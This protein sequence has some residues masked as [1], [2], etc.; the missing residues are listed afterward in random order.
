ML[1]ERGGVI[2]DL[3]V[4]YL[5]EDF[6]RLVVNA[7]TRDKDLAWIT[8][9]AAAFDVEVTERPDFAM[10]AVQG[11]TARERVLGL[12]SRRYRA[13]ADEARQVRRRRSGTND[14]VRC[15]SRAPATPARTVSRSSCRR[16]RPSRCGTPARRRA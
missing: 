6:F 7:A 10:I 14:G 1:N 12:L 15:S 13:A 9:Q 3:I 5:A 2:D 16:T 4:Y 8:Q 11:P